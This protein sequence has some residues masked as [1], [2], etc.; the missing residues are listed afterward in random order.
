MKKAAK[1]NCVGIDN[2]ATD[3]NGKR[4]ECKEC[5]EFLLRREKKCSLGFEDF[6][7]ECSNEPEKI[8]LRKKNLFC[9]SGPNNALSKN[10]WGPKEWELYFNVKLTKKQLNKVKFPWGRKVLDAPCPFHSE[11]SIK[12]THFAFLGLPDLF[13]E[14][15]TILKWHEILSDKDQP[16]FY[17]DEPWYA[18]Q[19]FAQDS[20]CDLRWY[21]MPLEVIP[22]STNKIY[23]AQ[24]MMLPK[25]Y[26]VPKAVEEVTKVLLYF[27]KN[28]TFLNWLRWGRT[29][30]VTSASDPVSVGG[31]DKF[32]LSVDDG[33]DSEETTGIATSR[34]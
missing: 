26:G 17:F 10:F 3:E 27:F 24:V 11:K 9:E 29:R 6:C 12:E 4:I 7:P 8:T 25:E 18:N 34:Y 19:E 22:N 15:L 21:L 16:K 28:A 23:Q 13:N 33:P 20:V 2:Y 14:P 5:A 31:F 32:G 30:D 1:E